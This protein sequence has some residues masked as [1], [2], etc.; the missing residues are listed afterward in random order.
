M[1]Q[2]I[3]AILA[4]L[5]VCSIAFAQ[6][7]YEQ[8]TDPGVRSLL[9]ANPQTMDE[10]META[11]LMKKLMRQ[12]LSKVFLKKI[13]DENPGDEDWIRLNKT[14]QKITPA[15]LQEF[16]QDESLQPIGSQVAEKIYKVLE[17]T[18]ESDEAIKNSV[19]SFLE[20]Q[21]GSRESQ[22]AFVSLN[23]T[24][25]KGVLV[26][27]DCLYSNT[28]KIKSASAGG[29]GSANGAKE[30]TAEEIAAIQ[31]QSRL[32]RTALTKIEMADDPLIACLDSG[33]K[34]FIRESLAILGRRGNPESV[35]YLLAFD[36]PHGD[37]LIAQTAQLA[38]K[39][40]HVPLVANSSGAVILLKAAQRLLDG[41]DFA[42]GENDGK[43]NVWVWNSETKKPECLERGEKVARVMGAVRLARGAFRR[44][45]DNKSVQKMYLACEAEYEACFPDD[46]NV[47]K[48]V[49]QVL[50][51][52]IPESERMIQYQELLDFAMKY[53]YDAAAIKACGLIA[54][55]KDASVL[56][57]AE[58]SSSVLIRA[59]A[60][61]NPAVRWAT[62]EAMIQINP[63]N[64]Y[65]G[66]CAL[67]S[68]LKW[69]IQGN[70]EQKI[71]IVCPKMKDAM[72]IA[73]FLPAPYIAVPAT[74]GKQ[75]FD[76]LTDES[77]IAAVLYSMDMY[78]VPSEIFIE[79]IREIPA[80]AGLPVA[81]MARQY[82][83]SK[84]R[85][86]VQTRPYATWFPIPA[87]PQD[88]DRGITLL[89]SVR[90]N[91]LESSDIVQQRAAKAIEYAANI[92]E[93]SYGSPYAMNPKLESPNPESEPA[94]TK[95]KADSLSDKT[96]KTKSTIEDNAPASEEEDPFTNDNMDNA[97]DDSEP[98][99]TVPD[100]NETP[101]A[102]ADDSG[103]KSAP[104]A[105]NTPEA[106]NSDSAPD[107]DDPFTDSNNQVDEQDDPFAAFS[108]ENQG[109]AKKP[110]SKDGKDAPADDSAK[111]TT[112]L[113]RRDNPFIVEIVSASKDLTEQEKSEI[114][115]QEL[116]VP[117]SASDTV[118][119]ANTTDTTNSSDTTA[120]L[121][122]KK[123]TM[124]NLYNLSSL[125]PVMRNR[126]MEDV[127]VENALKML[128]CIPVAEA[129][130]EIVL[131]ASS[132]LHSFDNRKLAL[133]AL[134]RSVSQFGLLMKTGQITRQY[135]ITNSE[136]EKGSVEVLN[137]ILDII[138]T[139]WLKQTDKDKK[140]VDDSNEKYYPK[141]SPFNE[142]PKSL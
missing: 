112:G 117:T 80:A 21:W 58:P 28:Q 140:A 115:D 129:Q 73:A 125:I 121:D 6:I 17:K 32:I 57:A 123:Q 132:K 38:L 64:P 67:I 105:D 10:K 92:A 141:R 36:T 111:T 34:D 40:A 77:D 42:K 56:D 106:N 81:L 100:K 99:N 135:E 94:S 90:R 102:A 139:P 126:L 118:D 87:N 19:Q 51:D 7:S 85:N 24:G 50:V 15:Y 66:S 52:D 136:T 65:L 23:K 16:T 84:A 134:D 110:Q 127:N 101:D 103:P 18:Y 128:S 98:D 124:R 5:A 89:N 83:F 49:K 47:K 45:P 9:A 4:T 78:S 88:M 95:E 120:N 82:D 59:L 104:E 33:G 11:I 70:G 25:V 37:E 109:D 96:D 62:C 75:A 54:A 2:F 48:Q 137:S 114:P 27:I 76:I 43:A 3:L 86:L 39:E 133:K 122:E 138:E 29:N 69:F 26:L 20:A 130:Y 55:L 107:G 30:L 119:T 44:L 53:Q 31:A 113:R 108:E 61:P 74:T 12:D 41:K 8:E 93:S 97:S 91:P 71:L 72:S 46:A 63:Q 14:A 60:H 22:D 142:W 1:K 68:N 131:Y 116:A 13:L 35:N 79:K